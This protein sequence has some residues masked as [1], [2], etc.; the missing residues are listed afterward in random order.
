M[1]R[2]VLLFGAMILR[3]PGGSLRLRVA[4]IE[5]RD[6]QTKR[7]ADSSRSQMVLRETFSLWKVRICSQMRSSRSAG[8][9][10]AAQSG[11]AR[12]SASTYAILLWPAS[13]AI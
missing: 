7:N 6:F 10:L 1:K 3:L 12:L 13:I 9:G 5:R 11:S 8:P 2:I 4:R